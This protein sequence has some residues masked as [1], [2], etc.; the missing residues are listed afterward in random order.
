MGE[1]G[2]VED[3]ELVH[4]AGMTRRRALGVFGVLAAGAAGLTGAVRA[5]G[6]PAPRAKVATGTTRLV[7]RYGA[8][9]DRVG[10]W[11]L[12]PQAAPAARLPTVVLVHGG[13]W[14]PGYDRHLEDAV[15]ADLAARGFL[16]WL[17]DYVSSAAPWPTTLLDMAAAYDWLGQGRYAGSVDPARVAVVGHS[18]GGHL[19]LWL[20]AR[21]RLPLR[22]P[23]G[24][25][26][27]GPAPGSAPRPA[28]AVGQAPVAA[29]ALGAS[30]RLGGGAVQALLGGGPDKVPE[31]Y[32]VAD[33]LALLPSRVRTV[34]VHGTS[35]GT[36]PLQQSE[37]YVAAARAAG[38]DSELVRV[39]GGHFEHLDP[40]SE[41]CARLRDALA[42]L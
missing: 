16:C 9:A 12:P 37:T 14:R 28:L 35:D 8:G 30:Q 20:A 6:S 27:A 22:A 42:T 23:G 25:P 31:R 41:A 40:R 34:L 39:P 36:V 24:L 2:P 26:A 33:P 4:D 29:L 11:W 15:A 19:A 32:R 3:A 10:E 21:G 18:A 17:P 1:A 7:E 38:D 13:Y 5:L